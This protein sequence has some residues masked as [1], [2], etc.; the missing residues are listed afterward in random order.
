MLGRGDKG[1]QGRQGILGVRTIIYTQEQGRFLGGSSVDSGGEGRALKQGVL[2]MAEDI[3][4][5]LE[6]ER[7]E[8]RLGVVAVDA[9]DGGF[10]FCSK[11]S[12]H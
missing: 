6:S 8:H 11:R 2:Y 1:R 10:R 5:W 12:K 7:E 4:V 9:G 3:L